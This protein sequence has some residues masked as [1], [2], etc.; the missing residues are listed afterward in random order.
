MHCKSCLKKSTYFS[1]CMHPYCESC[2]KN[3]TY[4]NNCKSG[5]TYSILE[6][7]LKFLNLY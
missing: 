5:K 7:I 3:K 2:Y 4:C 6:N 1:K